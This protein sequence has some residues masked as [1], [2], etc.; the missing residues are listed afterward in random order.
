[1]THQITTAIETITPTAA[2]GWLKQNTFNRP[3]ND[4]RVIQYMCDIV[5]N[6][7][8]V[9]GETVKFHAD[10]RLLDGQH[11]LLACVEAKKSFET[12]VV[13]GIT[14]EKAFATIDVGETRTHGDIFHIAGFPDQNNIS[15]MATILYFMEK[16]QVSLT[17]IGM[18]NALPKVLLLE[19]ANKRRDALIACNRAAGVNP[20]KKFLPQSMIGAMMYLFAQKNNAEAEDFIGKLGSGE[21]LTRTDPVYVLRE[22]LIE[23]SMSKEKL[24]RPLVLAYCITAWNKTRAGES[25]K[26]I[27]LAEE[28]PK[29]K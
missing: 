26:F 10:G 27:K 18:K 13:R 20:A 12:M 9:N 21:G 4:N 5:D 7:W 23:N 11:R 22:K 3:V 6:K 28:F 17:K 1:M 2:A 15:S 16:K 29:I 14:D 8:V 25:S 24:P 19:W